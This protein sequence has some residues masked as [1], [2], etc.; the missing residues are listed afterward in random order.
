MTT[1]RIAAHVALLLMLPSVAQA[2]ASYLSVTAATGPDGYRSTELRGN[3]DLL[4]TPLNVNALVFKSD[5]TSGD[6]SSQSAFGMDWSASDLL[7]LGASHSKQDNSQVEISGN[8]LGLKLML[9]TLWKGDLRTRIDLKHGVSAYR[10]KGLPPA[11]TSD[12][13]NQ[14][15]DSLGLNQDLAS[16]VTIYLYH[17]QYRYDRDPKQ[18]ALYLMRAA[19]RR[20]SN[21]RTSL[22]SSP[23]S[24]NSLGI[25]WRM[26]DDLML[27]IS[28]SKTTTQLDQEQTSRRLGLDYQMS[29]RI[30]ITAS[31]I[32]ATS[33]AV[34]TKQ[35]LF[36]HLPALTIPAGTIVLPATHDRYAELGLGWSF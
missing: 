29:D 30:N 14:T 19:P 13:I 4:D 3:A 22:L 32:F 10:Y 25:T 15:V 21:T 24:S 18:A 6:S 9:D 12:T 23:D 1:F 8:S 7:M 26:R 28:T 20:S 27:D 33:T 36:P 11:V 17:D 5:S 16:P 31:V 34:V 2:G 35:T